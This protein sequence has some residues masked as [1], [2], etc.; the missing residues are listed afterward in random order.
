MKHLMLSI[1][2]TIPVFTGMERSFILV[3]ITSGI[4]T[5]INAYVIALMLR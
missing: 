1:I 3:P 5:T 2:A 4:V